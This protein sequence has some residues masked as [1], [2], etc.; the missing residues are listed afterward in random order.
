MIDQI[1]ELPEDR[2]KSSPETP[3]FTENKWI[4]RKNQNKLYF[5]QLNCVALNGFKYDKTVNPVKNI[6]LINLNIFISYYS[7][8]SNTYACLKY[9]QL[10]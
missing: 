5:L 4:S 10:Q 1:N 2:L 6:F 7:F 3:R 9:H 8:S